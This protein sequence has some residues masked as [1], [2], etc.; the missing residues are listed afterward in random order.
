M[1]MIG[2]HASSALTCFCPP[3]SKAETAPGGR[4]EKVNRLGFLSGTS[5][6]LALL[7]SLCTAVLT[8]SSLRVV[9]GVAAL[10]AGILKPLEP[11]H[12]DAIIRVP[13]LIIAIAGSVT[14]LLVLAWIWRMRRLP[15]AEWRKRE[16]SKK[17]KRS[18]RLQVALAVAT[19]IL[20]ALEAWIHP[21]L[22]HGAS[23]F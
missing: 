5:L 19:L 22:N 23:A 1:L 4:L 2:R 12:H 17:E 15:S 8:I 10:S 13:M 9:I 16:I 20:V 21:I 3:R 11:L 6:L 14:N 7:Q 18:E